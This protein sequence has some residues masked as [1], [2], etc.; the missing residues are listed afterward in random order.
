MIFLLSSVYAYAER[1]EIQQEAINNSVSPG[2][3]A[4]FLLK[5]RNNKNTADDFKIS[6]N[7]LDVYPFSNLIESVELSKEVLK[8]TPGESVTVNLK[9]KVFEDATP[10]VNYKTF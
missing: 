9:L 5:I 10:N 4:E 3:T 2:E 6:V 8:L 7:E 1:V